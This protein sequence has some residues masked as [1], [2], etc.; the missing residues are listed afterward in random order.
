MASRRDWSET[1]LAAPRATPFAF[2]EAPLLPSPLPILRN[3]PRSSPTCST[4]A[5]RCLGLAGSD[6]P[7]VASRYGTCEYAKARVAGDA[8][9][10]EFLAED[11]A[12]DYVEDSEGWLAS[13]LPLRADL[14]GGDLR[15]LYLGWLRCA[16]TEEL[17]DDAVEP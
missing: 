14:A 13:L 17:D 10:L 16:Q 4:L 1:G 5:P 11:E 3:G 15:C 9:I 12:S 2:P 6:E 7:A 8:V